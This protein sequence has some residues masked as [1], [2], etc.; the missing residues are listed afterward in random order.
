MAKKNIEITFD[1]PTSEIREALADIRAYADSVINDT[2]KLVELAAVL[3]ESEAKKH[4]PVDSGRLR[5]SIENRVEDLT[6]IVGTDVEYAPFVEMG[7]RNMKAQ[8]FL[9]P[10]Y[11]I[12]R[13]KFTDDIKR[14]LKKRPRKPK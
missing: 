11:E 4:A 10:A 12:V 2:R 6:A 9:N 8:P 5:A 13:R 3:M 1:I 14:M 7:T